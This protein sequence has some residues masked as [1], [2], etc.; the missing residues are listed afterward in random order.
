MPVVAAVEE[1][2]E[3]WHSWDGSEPH[4]DNG[5]FGVGYVAYIGFS[6]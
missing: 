1:S 4:K 5:N 2:C 6:V 3:H